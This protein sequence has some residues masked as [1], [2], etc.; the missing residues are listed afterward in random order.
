MVASGDAAIS[1]SNSCIDGFGVEILLYSGEFG[2]TYVVVLVSLDSLSVVNI[3]RGSHWTGRHQIIAIDH[4]SPRWWSWCWHRTTDGMIIQYRLSSCRPDTTTSQKPQ[5]EHLTLKRYNE[6]PRKVVI[7]SVGWRQ[8]RGKM[9]LY[10]RHK[11][12]EN[13]STVQNFSLRV[14]VI[15]SLMH[16]YIPVQLVCRV[17]GGECRDFSIQ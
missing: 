8:R 14:L 7:I 16:F 3:P 17:P 6:C 12:T 11:G 2:D 15:C 10:A 5:R 9:C 13:N 4:G 1:Y